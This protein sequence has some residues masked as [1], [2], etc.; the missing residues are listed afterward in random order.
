METFMAGNNDKKIV[1]IKRKT[2]D[3]HVHHGGSWKIAYAD[4]VTA[5]M[6][7]FLL[8]WLVASLNKAQ[9]DGISEY[10]K[11]PLRIAFIGGDSTG[12]RA[13]TING[14]GDNLDKHDGQVSTASQNEMKQLQQ[15]KTNILLS[16][17]NDP[18]LVDLKD[19]LLMDI[20]SEGLRIQLIDNKNKPMFPLGSDQM[21]P[22]VQQIL[23]KIAKLLNNVPNKI[24]IQ[25]HTDAN[26]YDNPEDLTQTNWELSTQ[27]A[28]AAR[29]ALLKGGLQENKVMEV[30]G[31]AS[32]VLL[33][34][35]N[36]LNPNNRRISIIVMKK[37][38]E[39]KLI[40]NK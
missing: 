4:F 12:S 15:L 31:F 7:F 40:K 20:V 17:H 24:S 27:R 18:S 9:K 32:T 13:E 37:E 14:G 33:D 36:P 29:R 1:I 8:M 21:D 16:V 30:T 5:M 35:K 38:V 2:N 39:E 28:N 6:A 25:G 10:F 3:R 11:Q 34:K 22:N 19:R 26:P 23:D